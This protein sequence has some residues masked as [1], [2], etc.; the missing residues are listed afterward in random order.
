M[1]L[2]LPFVLASLF[3]SSIAAAQERDP[4]APPPPPRDTVERRSDDAPD[5][6][7]AVYANPLA[8]ALGV[9]G[10]EVDLAL[11]RHVALSLEGAR[12]AIDGVV[13]HGVGVGAI[14]FPTHGAF[15]GLFVHPEIAYARVT[16]GGDLVSSGMTIGYAWTWDAGFSLR[17]GGGVAYDRSTAFASGVRP[18]LDA[19][20]GWAF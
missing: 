2:S 15:E 5:R 18:T 12:Y 14:V 17:L 7:V 13:A 4:E 19:S 8:L 6:A 1:K 3:A 9:L 16:G 10:A 11:A 20:V